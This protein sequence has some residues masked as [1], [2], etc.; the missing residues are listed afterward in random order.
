ML[1]ADDIN[2]NI[3]EYSCVID[4]ARTRGIVRV[5][6]RTKLAPKFRAS[7]IALNDTLNIL[8][9]GILPKLITSVLWTFLA[10]PLLVILKWAITFCFC[11]EY[12]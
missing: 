10:A 1:P 3:N 5:E 7:I 11:L 12:K 4:N 9:V 8:C 6:S 2:L